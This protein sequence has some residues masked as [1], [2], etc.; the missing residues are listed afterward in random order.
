M[1]S[2]VCCQYVGPIYFHARSTSTGG[3]APYEKFNDGIVATVKISNNEK[4]LEVGG[5]AWD[6]VKGRVGR[7]DETWGE[8]SLKLAGRTPTMEPDLTSSNIEESEA[9]V[10]TQV[11]KALLFWGG[12][13]EW[14]KVQKSLLGS[15]SARISQESS[16]RKATMFYLFGQ[17]G[18]DVEVFFYG[19]VGIVDRVRKLL[20]MAKVE[21]GSMMTLHADQSGITVNPGQGGL[22]T[23][24]GSQALQA[25]AEEEDEGFILGAVGTLLL[26]SGAQYRPDKDGQWP[27]HLAVVY[28]RFELVR[29][30]LTHKTN[31][32][33]LEQRNTARR[34]AM[35]L[36]AEHK[37]DKI[38]RLLI[39]SGNMGPESLNAQD[40]EGQTALTVAANRGADD[41]TKLLVQKGADTAVQDITQL[42]QIALHYGAAKGY[43]RCVSVLLE[44]VNVE[45]GERTKSDERT[46]GDDNNNNNNNNSPDDSR[47]TNKGPAAGANVDSRNSDGMTALH[48]ASMHGHSDVVR[49]LLAPRAKLS[50]V[51]AKGQTALI[52]AVT[53]GKAETVKQLLEAQGREPDQEEKKRLDMALVS[54]V[55][56]LQTGVLADDSNTIRYRVLRQL[57]DAGA[58]S[59]YLNPSDGK[60]ALHWAVKTRA[61]DGEFVADLLIKDMVKGDK[62][63]DRKEKATEQSALIMA[64]AKKWS[65]FALRLMEKGADVTLRDSGGRTVLHWAALTQDLQV[66][67]EILDQHKKRLD[68][69][70]DEKDNHKRTALHLAA[71]RSDAR[72]ALVTEALLGARSSVESRDVLWTDGLDGGSSNG[73]SGCSKTTRRKKRPNGRGQIQK[74]G[75]R[76]GSRKRLRRSRRGIVACRRFIDHDG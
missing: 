29:S 65:Y 6:Y 34:T 61:E 50:A 12:N 14:R 22:D 13:L 46:D 52:L 19:H 42:N 74:D 3:G 35:H 10:N 72:E 59:G 39:E 53:H 44:Q 47:D 1:A 68:A 55:R 17:E 15:V 2:L 8:P 20:P 7:H 38:A 37:R 48:L 75:T 26:D 69:L 54:A 40:V 67:N 11:F 33:N 71:A 63:L 23:T 56:S 57:L 27:I 45:Q 31:P 51:D 9:A 62:R 49:I 70:L 36:A 4:M 5:D 64:M 41:I 21:P 16:T 28:D 66:V 32:V 30:M 60:T 25:L 73:A 43:T 18:D 24:L 76:F 58:M